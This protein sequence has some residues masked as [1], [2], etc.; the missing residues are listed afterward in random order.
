MI[1]FENQTE[2]AFYNYL[3]KK[4]KESTAWD[5][6]RRIRSIKRLDMLLNEKLD[7]YIAAY[8][9]GAFA[10][11]NNTAHNAFSAALKHFRDFQ[12]L[13]KAADPQAMVL[14]DFLGK[15]VIRPDT[16]VRFV[17]TQIQA[18]AI[19]VRTTEPGS[20]GY[21][22]YYSYPTIN[23][24]PFTEGYLVFED[25]G[26]TEQFC[27]VFDAHCRSEDGYWETYDYWMRRD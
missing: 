21:Y 8:E 23:G 2:T 19:Q 22:S 13:H 20:H 12:Q 16:G 15:V 27:R 5:Y 1:K 25:A 18:P 24:D 4:F 6:I 26:L 10:K 14:K 17:I 11:V 3:T 9:T 7:S